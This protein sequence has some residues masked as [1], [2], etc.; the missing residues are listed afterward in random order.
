MI[1]T[2]GTR[3]APIAIDLTGDRRANV[4]FGSQGGTFSG[5]GSATSSGV[6]VAQT[7]TTVART[8]AP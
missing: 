8:T 4:T 3:A 1:G 2:D 6:A 5:G 7:P